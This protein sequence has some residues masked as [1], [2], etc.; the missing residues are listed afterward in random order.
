MNNIEIQRKLFKC[1]CTALDDIETQLTMKLAK[2]VFVNTN[3]FFQTSY[4]SVFSSE[5]DSLTDDYD[6]MTL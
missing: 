5:L 2:R 4:T 6:L 3:Q 1:A